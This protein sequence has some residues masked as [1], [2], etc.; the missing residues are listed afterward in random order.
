MGGYYNKVLV[1]Y[2]S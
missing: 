1:Y 2:S